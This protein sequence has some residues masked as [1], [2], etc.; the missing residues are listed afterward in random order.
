MELLKTDK[1]KSENFKTHVAN[2]L[3]KVL[4]VKIILGFQSVDN[5]L[6]L[7]VLTLLIL[8]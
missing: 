8:R 3:S 2:S 7:D 4:E 5:L 1:I 6:L